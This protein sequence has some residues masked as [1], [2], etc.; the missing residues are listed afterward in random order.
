MPSTSARTHHVEVLLFASLR[1]AVGADRLRVE[2]EPGATAG[3]LLALL[4][5]RHPTVARQGRALAVAVN[6]DVV[7]LG[8]RLAPG[9]EVALLPPVGGG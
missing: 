2:I 5:A 3:D 1:E 7:P 8:H 6:L 9:D 4:S